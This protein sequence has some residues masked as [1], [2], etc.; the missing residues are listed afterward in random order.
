MIGGVNGRLARQRFGGD[1][2]HVGGR[3]PPAAERIVALFS[4]LVALDAE[5][6]AE[7]ALDLPD[8][9]GELRLMALAFDQARYGSAERV[10]TVASPVVAQISVPRF[11]APGDHALLTLEL[12]NLSGARQELA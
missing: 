10:T 7:I 2:D 8:F 6:E 1:L 11:L 3:P 5:G 9:N 4:G 12:H